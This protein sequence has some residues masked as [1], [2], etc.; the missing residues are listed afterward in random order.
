MLFV[1]LHQSFPTVCSA[2]T[3]LSTCTRDPLRTIII[4]R[5]HDH[6]KQSDERNITQCRWLSF[7]FKFRLWL[8]SLW[9]NYLM[10]MGIRS[11]TFNQLNWNAF[12]QAKIWNKWTTRAAFRYHII[13]VFSVQQSAVRQLRSTRNSTM[14]SVSNYRCA[15]VKFA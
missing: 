9:S 2:S 7:G 15:F 10:R 11:T 8:N 12:K 13:H 14:A 5:P 6:Q 1:K 3:R 4:F